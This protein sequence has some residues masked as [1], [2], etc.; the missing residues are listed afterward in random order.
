MTERVNNFP[1]LPSVIPIKPCFYQNFEEEIPPQY[2]QL[3]RRAYNLWMLYSATLCVNVISCIAWWAGGGDGV[4][5]GFSLLW[6]LI[7]SPCSY[8]CWFRPLYKGFRA[9]SSFNF[10]LF[11]FVFFCQCVFVIIQA[12]GISGWG[13]WCTNFIVVAGAAFSVHRKS[14]AAAPGRVLL[15]V[16]QALMLSPAA[17][18]ISP[19]TQLLYRA[20]LTTA[21]GDATANHLVQ[22]ESKSSLLHTRS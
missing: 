11:F 4:N 5:F 12:V 6:L 20:T 18:L 14:G 15:S 17:A 7:F 21:A 22:T 10:M 16:M 3:V 13:A 1:P 8:T 9:D 19:I 2:R